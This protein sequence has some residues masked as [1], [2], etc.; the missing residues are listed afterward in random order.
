MAR[1]GIGFGGGFGMR[2]LALCGALAIAAA[3]GT[4][5]AEQ[6]DAN[7]ATRT[8]AA[9]TSPSVIR[10]GAPLRPAGA[11]VAARHGHGDGLIR[12]GSPS[13]IRSFRP[14]DG[15][16]QSPAPADAHRVQ[17][18]GATSS[19]GRV[20]MVDQATAAAR[21]LASD[22]VV[23]RRVSDTMTPD[24]MIL[25][26][27]DAKDVQPMIAVDPFQ[28]IDA[29]YREQLLRDH[30]YIT[31]AQARRAEVDL[32]AARAQW[33]RETGLANR[34][35]QIRS[36]DAARV[37]AAEQQ[38]TPVNHEPAAIIVPRNREQMTMIEPSRTVATPAVVA[39]AQPVW[40]VVP[41]PAPVVQVQPVVQ[42][43]VH[44]VVVQP[45]ATGWGASTSWGTHVGLGSVCVDTQR[46]LFRSTSGVHISFSTGSWWSK[47]HHHHHHHHR[48]HHHHGHSKHGHHSHGHKRRH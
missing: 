19:A 40:A 48:H 21:Q 35:I 46:S 18:I 1:H 6:A 45:V 26:Q 41:P 34:V 24:G 36:D 28:T 4:A 10:S 16:L 15:V 17:Q 33:Q 8:V 27:T 20:V 13:V 44:P 14:R 9:S 47:H 32:I 7:Q 30:P 22:P 3:G 2:G 31:D 29:R 11:V 25:V 39:Q 37:Q 42:Q 38:R 43:V 12:S 5:L 23:A